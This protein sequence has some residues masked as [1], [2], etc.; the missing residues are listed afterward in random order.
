MRKLPV[1]FGEMKAG[2]RKLGLLPGAPEAQREKMGGLGGGGNRPGSG[3]AKKGTGKRSAR[4][5]K[6]RRG[7]RVGRVKKDAH[8]QESLRNSQDN[9][10]TRFWTSFWL[11]RE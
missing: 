1:P 6:E 4:K 5:M 2:R 9:E 8:T 7:G 3:S 11:R 10:G